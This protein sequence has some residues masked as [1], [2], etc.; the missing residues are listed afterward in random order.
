MFYSKSY[1][2]LFSN[3]QSIINYILGIVIEDSAIFVETI[4]FLY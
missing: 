2:F 4:T 3:K 1:E